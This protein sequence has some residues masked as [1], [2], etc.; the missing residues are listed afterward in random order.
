MSSIKTT[1]DIDLI[2][3]LLDELN[4]LKDEFIV[5][6]HN[7][8]GGMN[9][10][11]A[12]ITADAFALAVNHIQDSLGVKGDEFAKI[13]FQKES[14]NKALVHLQDF[15]AALHFKIENKTNNN[16]DKRV[17]LEKLIERIR[18]TSILINDSPVTILLEQ[19]GS[20]SVSTDDFVAYITPLWDA[21]YDDPTQHKIAVGILDPDGYSHDSDIDFPLSFSDIDKDY[22]LYL[23]VIERELETHIKFGLEEIAKNRFQSK[24]V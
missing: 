11:L 18:S 13:Y 5:P 4:E 16:G 8:K 7:K 1:P 22:A 3:Q 23:E 6:Q 10:K 21:D 24:E 15:S 12:I 14:S 20:L 2:S 17:Y 9:N 19:T